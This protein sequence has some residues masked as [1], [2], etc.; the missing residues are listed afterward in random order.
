[1][2]KRGATA[3]REVT[4]GHLEAYQQAIVTCGIKPVT[5]QDKFR[6]VLLWF[7][8]L[9]DYG[10]L[11][12]NPALVLD[13]PR[14]G[15]SLPRPILSE[16]EFQHLLSLANPTTL[17]G[18]RDRCIFQ[19]LYASAMRP[20]ELC[21][22]TCGDADLDH[23][24]ILIRRPKNKR[25]RLVHV[26]AYTAQE[27][28]QYLTRLETW[29]GPRKPSDP[30]FINANGK[31]L[32]RGTLQFHF[33]RQYTP[34]FKEKFG[35]HITLYSIRH[36]SATDWLDAGFT[37][38]RDLLPFVQRQLGHESMDS[39]AV[40]THVAIEPL[41]QMFKKFH[42]RERQ[43]SSLSGIPGSAEDLESRWDSQ[44]TP[45]PPEPPP[46]H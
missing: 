34:R 45:P 38:N 33:A 31:P 7:T 35:K 8:Y 3:L 39:T 29:L 19:V 10:Y 9:C 44:R 23:Q 27:L 20:G 30:L 32:L 11:A 22:L 24:Q 26:D 15:Q 42:P 4:R 6:V 5:Q 36:S 13:P 21:R 28:R 16:A 46:S 40:Y 37:K 2:R 43:F 18:L 25:D 41:R 1:M 14:R 12:A 17:P